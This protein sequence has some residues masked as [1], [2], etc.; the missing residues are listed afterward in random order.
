MIRRSLTPFLAH[1]WF[2]EDLKKDLPIGTRFVTLKENPTQF[3]PDLNAI[4]A[5]RITGKFKQMKTRS[6]HCQKKPYK[7]MSELVKSQPTFDFEDVEGNMV[8]F[9]SPL[10]MSGVALAGWHLHF[11]T[12]DGKTGGHVLEFTTADSNMTSDRSV[13]FHWCIPDTEEYQ[14]TKF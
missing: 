9:W 1:A 2:D 14:Q 11:I 8:G 12:K 10:A 3:L 6:M 7:V 4:H 5:V 13:D